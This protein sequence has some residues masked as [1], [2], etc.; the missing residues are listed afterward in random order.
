MT[1]SA[2]AIDLSSQAPNPLPTTPMPP[3]QLPPHPFDFSLS[4]ATGRTEAAFERYALGFLGYDCTLPAIIEAADE[5]PD[6]PGAQAH[7]AAVHMAAESR[8]GFDAAAIYLAQA[9]RSLG[10]ASARDR[11]FLRL[12]EAWHRQDYRRA[13]SESL[14]LI[15]RW[16]S[17]VIAAKWGQYHAFNL[18]D[19][20]ALLA[21]AQDTAA[22]YPDAPYVHG[23]EAFGLEQDHRP[24][25]AI[26]AAER[27]LAAL[28]SDG[29]THHALAHIHETAGAA[30]R[31]LAF[32]QAQSRHWGGMGKFIR[33]HNWWHTALFHMHLGDMAGAL[34]IYDRR[35]WGVSPGF[36]QEL[37]GAISA[38]WRLEL[39]GA[40]V[41]ERWAP[42]LETVR[43]RPREH[44]LPFLDLHYVY[45]LAR[46][47][48]D[49]DAARFIA[50]M[51]RTVDARP[52]YR[53]RRLWRDVAVPTARGLAAHG[54]GQFEVAA[55]HLA[56]LQ[57]DFSPLGGSH[58][59]R[60]VFIAT[61][62]DAVRRAASRG[63]A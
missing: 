16:P 45:A 39:G 36:S 52:D 23:M 21:L 54:L 3:S 51:A 44:V 37:V 62:E 14:A 57:E 4:A 32:M 43:S 41:G 40:D 7:A 2:T 30:E 22:T 8:E 12:V 35:L 56:P 58:A 48:H 25:E 47:G 42:I 53:C 15:K 46:A 34:D 1:A 49:A 59:Q 55:E 61:A 5:D 24:E 9:R 38:L 29:W 50:S 11:A 17:D 33:L 28:P 31:G 63:A 19:R 10:R 6:C 13:L 20:H 60:E 18:G 26:E 27:A